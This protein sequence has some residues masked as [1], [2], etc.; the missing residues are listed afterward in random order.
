[1]NIDRAREYVVIVNGGSGCIFR[2]S[3]EYIYILTAKHNITNNSNKLEPIKYFKFTDGTW[4]INEFILETF[5]EGENY[6]PHPDKD[7]AIIKIQCSEG[8]EDAIRL[9]ITTE[10]NGFSL[11]GYP[12]TR[13]ISNQDNIVEWFRRDDNLQVID[14]RL[15]GLYEGSLPNNPTIEEIKGHSG[16]CVLKVQGK[17]VCIL[18][19]QNKMAADTE[20]LGRLHFTPLN[21]FDEIIEINTTHLATISPCHL[22]SFSFLKHEAFNLQGG[23]ASTNIEFTKNFL[24]HKT[25]EVINSDLTPIGIKNMFNEKLLLL[26]Q[27]PDVLQSKGL[28]IIWLEF[29]TI[30]NLLK[31]ENCT[32]NSLIDIFNNIR[33]IYSDTN[34]DWSDEISNMIY[35]DYRGLKKNGVVIIGVA[36]PPADDETYILEK[37]IPHIG[38]VIKSQRN[39]HNRDLLQI[40]DGINFP[41]DSYKFI[42]IEY[43]KKQAIIKKHVDYANIEDDSILIAKLKS[44]YQILI[45]NE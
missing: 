9:E 19:I 22:K 23:F 31:N 4:T 28:W 18:G 41:L 3:Q 1:M 29:L 11:L 20:Q 32:E 10:K 6:F 34:G 7:I 42:H 35:S 24:N 30:L 44:E 13:R 16:G 36:K 5:V 25:I 12:E 2:P 21:S 26:N 27:S 45:E 14:P 38:N 8:F 39:G 33:L 15:N 43:F 37:S 40:D 17:K